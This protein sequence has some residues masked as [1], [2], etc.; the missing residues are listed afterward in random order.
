MKTPSR[1]DLLVMRAYLDAALSIEPYHHNTPELLRTLQSLLNGFYPQPCY[2]PHSDTAESN[3]PLVKEWVDAARQ[4]NAT[5]N[6]NEAAVAEAFKGVARSATFSVAEAAL[7]E[8][9][10]FKD[11]SRAAVISLGPNGLKLEVL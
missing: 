11:E 4:F 3:D 10:G 7:N 1:T 8:G 9:R 6:A 2:R 5:C